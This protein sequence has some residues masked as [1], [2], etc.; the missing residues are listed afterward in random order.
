MPIA[1]HP[2]LDGIDLVVFDKDGTLISFDAM[3]S[4][5][6]REL[7]N[8]LELA[9]RRPVAGDI[10]TTI[11]FDPV[12]NRIAP[13]GP[14]AI[15]T[16]G[17]IQEVVGAVLRRW[18]PSVNAARRILAEAWFE[19]D[20]VASLVP[21]ADLGV[22]FGTLR[23]ADRRIAIATTDDRRPTE[24][25][26]AA[27]GLSAL[28]DDIVCGDDDGPIKPD[29]EALAA[30]AARLGIAIERTVMVGDTP[31]DLRMA[32]AAGARAIGVT[33]GVA[34]AAELAPDANLV[35]AT[36]ATLLGPATIT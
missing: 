7:G 9:T 12:V 24:A 34:I 15:A 16:M 3:W 36:I 23:N 10:F 4:G 27:L 20:P 8:R 32:R 19:P 31:A 30:I 21:L 6:A 29:P 1:L 11:G 14:L 18:C 35:I 17:Q 28:V 5:W 33:S 22:L 25:T 26:I 2:I 13:N